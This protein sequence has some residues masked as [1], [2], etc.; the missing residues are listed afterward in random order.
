[1]RKQITL[2]VTERRFKILKELANK[3]GS[4]VAILIT[5]M[6]DELADVE[7]DRQFKLK[8]KI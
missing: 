6:V 4:S 3:K 1:M 5:D 8:E 2:F 7:A